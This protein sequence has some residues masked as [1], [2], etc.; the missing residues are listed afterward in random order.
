[1]GK[2]KLVERFLMDDYNPT[3]LSTYA[4]NTFRQTATVEGKSVEVEFWDTVSMG[5][6]R[7][8]ATG[9]LVQFGRG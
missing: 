4:L 1:M 9:S 8:P 6:Q 7:P 3:Q 5:A 2:S